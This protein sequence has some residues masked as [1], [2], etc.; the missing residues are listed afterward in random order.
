VAARDTQTS[1]CTVICSSLSEN[2]FSTVVYDG[3]AS[4]E[5]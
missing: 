5:L 4:V 1:F 3:V 2:R